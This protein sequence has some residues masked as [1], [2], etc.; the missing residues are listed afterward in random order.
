MMR[1]SPRLLVVTR[2]LVR[3]F[4]VFAVGGFLGIAAQSAIDYRG[5]AIVYNAAPVDTTTMQDAGWA[6][7]HYDR[8]REKSCPSRVV[9]ALLR[10]PEAT[11]ADR[12]AGAPDI[13]PLGSETGAVLLSHGREQFNLYVQLPTDLPP[14]PWPWYVQS[15]AFDMCHPWS[16]ITNGSPR[17]SP[18]IPLKPST[19]RNSE[20]GR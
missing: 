13:L 19:I 12:F 10:F 6:K 5:P 7:L 8:T 15:V 3:G 17:V 20:G 11:A 4:S 16:F 18:L 1:L 14:G 9:R 2:P